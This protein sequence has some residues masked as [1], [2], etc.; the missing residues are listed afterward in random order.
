[1]LQTGPNV[2]AVEIHQGNATS[3]DL[4]FDLELVGVPVSSTPP[5]ELYVGAFEEGLVLGWGDAAY[6]LEEAPTV[7]GPWS[8]STARS[9][10]PVDPNQPKRFFRLVK[11]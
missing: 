5:Q 4:S 7:K 11:P 2:I 9:P 6:Q 10:F 1:M 8:R 3:S